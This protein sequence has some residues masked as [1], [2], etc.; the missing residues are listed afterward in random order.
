MVGTVVLV[1]V[2]SIASVP[3]TPLN[4]S[5]IE[6]VT[7]PCAAGYSGWFGVV[8]SGDHVPASSTVA[9]FP[10]VTPGATALS[11]VTGRQNQ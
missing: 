5:A 9:G 3:S 7:H 1:R 4:T 6:E 10:S 2:R 8:R 11:A